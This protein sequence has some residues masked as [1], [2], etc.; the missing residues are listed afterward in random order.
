MDKL[1]R[2]LFISPLEFKIIRVFFCQISALIAFHDKGH[3]D[4]CANCINAVIIAMP[5]GFHNK[6][7]IPHTQ[8]GTKTG[9][10]FILRAIHP[11]LLTFVLT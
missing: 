10:C 1:Q 5:V 2:G 6:F 11:D 8:V 3:D 4:S 9:G 7:R